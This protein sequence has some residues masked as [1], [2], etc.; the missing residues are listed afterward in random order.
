MSN[1]GNI[2][3]IDNVT[4]GTLYYVRGYAVTTGYK[5]GYGDVIRVYTLPKGNITWNYDNEGDNAQNARISQAVSGAINYWNNLTVYQTCHIGVV[6]IGVADSGTGVATD[7]KL[8]G[9][10]KGYIYAFE[11]NK[12]KSSI[13]YLAIGFGKEAGLRFG[14]WK[15]A[16]IGILVLDIPTFYLNSLLSSEIS[17]ICS[18]LATCCG[19]SMMNVVPFV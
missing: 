7:N 13:R 1:G 9:L 4:P 17:L 2:Y 12:E 11:V 6:L 14:D 16:V 10:V 8:Y 18:S 3:C 5:V 19:I 15:K